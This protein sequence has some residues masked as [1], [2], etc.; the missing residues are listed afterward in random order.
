MRKKKRDTVRGKGFLCLF[1]AVATLV[2][3]MNTP[4]K[5]SARETDSPKN[6]V[7]LGGY[8]FGTR[9]STKGVLVVGLTAVTS[10]NKE[11]FPAR[12]AGICSGDIINTVN[13]K[14]VQSSEDLVASIENSNEGALEITLLRENSEIKVSLKAVKSDSDGTYKAGLWV[15]DSLAGIGT[16]TFIIPQTREFVGL[17]HGMCDSDTG[18]IMP[19]R[20]GSVFGVSLGD[21]KRSS[22]GDPGELRGRLVGEKIGEITQNT[23][24]GVYGRLDSDMSDRL[25][26]LCDKESVKTGE[27]SVICTLDSSSPKEYSAVIERICD[28][29][30]ETKNFIIRITDE[31]LIAKTGGIVQGM[32]GSPIIQDGKLVG[33]VTHVLVDD[34]TRG[35]GIFVEN[36]LNAAQMPMAKAS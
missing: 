2:C 31:E 16:V 5:V 26:S 35:Y 10:G 4:Y 11:L 30:G 9:I 24:C 25:V 14:E 13:G 12:D 27:A 29:S 34:P 28:A 17:G 22:V 33:A 18:V 36:M 19:V 1:F 7:Y 21:I 8:V 15:R 20:E 6:E 3:V 32:S 23:P